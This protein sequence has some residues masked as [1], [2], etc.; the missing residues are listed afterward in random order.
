MSVLR[1]IAQR[2]VISLLTLLLVAVIVFVVVELLPGDVATRILGRDATPETIALFR[3]RMNLDAPP[4]ERF[5]TWLGGVVTGDLGYALT[6][7]RPIVRILGPRI[8]NTLILSGLALLLYIPLSL[9]P[10]M[11]QAVFRDRPIDQFLSTLNL[12]AVSLPDFLLGTILLIAFA[13]TVPLFPAMSLVDETSD[14]AE[15]LR[16]CALPG[17]TLA[18]VM[19]AYAI[20][21][22]R[23]N[24]VEILDADFIR[25][26]ELKGMP[27]RKVLVRHALP[28]SLVPTLNITALNLGY[29]IGGVVI[30]ERVFSY[31]GFGSL[32]VDALTLRD[33]PLIEATVLI[34]AAVYIVAN[35]LADVG[36]ILLN[37]RL[38][39]G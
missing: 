21:M 37:P 20:R 10:A 14:V 25:M 31:P 24:L 28:N 3:E 6:S 38:R 15:Y 2:L 11:L 23:D 18:I 34:A 1:L 35:L 26:A 39:Q 36:A 19:A 12:I 30:V 16:A 29:V 32:M 17:L 13:V 5:A 33:V 7:G 8:Q 9:V 27:R 22:L 4:A